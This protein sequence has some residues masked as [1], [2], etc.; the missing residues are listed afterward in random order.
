MRVQYAGRGAGVASPVPFPWD[1][2]LE[3]RVERHLFDVRKLPSLFWVAIVASVS[4]LIGPTVVIGAGAR[5][6]VDGSINEGAQP[7]PNN[8]YVIRGPSAELDVFVARVGVDGDDQSEFSTLEFSVLGTNA[9]PVRVADEQTG[10]CLD[11][12]D[13]LTCMSE[14]PQQARIFEVGLISADDLRA[15][16]SAFQVKVSDAPLLASGLGEPAVVTFNSDFT[17]TVL[18]SRIDEAE[19]TL[20]MG[21]GGLLPGVLA[22]SESF[23]GVVGPENRSGEQGLVITGVSGLNHSRIRAAAAESTNIDLFFEEGFDS[24]LQ[25]VATWA[26]RL[27]LLSVATLLVIVGRILG[28]QQSTTLNSLRN[29]GL[30]RWRLV[31]LLVSQSGLSTMGGVLASVAGSTGILAFL[32]REVDIVL[33]AHFSMLW[34]L[35]LGLVAGA[36]ILIAY[37]AASPSYLGEQ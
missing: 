2:E 5:S 29:I 35:V 36:A 8:A 16:R 7:A 23:D 21:L 33:Q 20:L 4:L 3:L 27:A 11:R 28:F 19:A 9:N 1:E 31:Q 32:S 12:S 15:L 22:T 13:I 10:R 14:S 25:E 26:P 18:L 24:R 17:D 6:L 30:S 37:M 34:H